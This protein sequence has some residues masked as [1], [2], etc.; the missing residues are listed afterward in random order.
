[1]RSA[2]SRTF[3]K[4]LLLAMVAL[5]SALAFGQ[6]SKRSDQAIAPAKYQ[7]RLKDDAFIKEGAAIFVPSC[8]ST[9][10]HGSAGMG[11]SAPRLRGR[12]LE[13]AYIFK[14]VSGGVP[15]TPMVSFKS[16]LTEEQRWKVVAF[17]MSPVGP[18]TGAGTSV[19]KVGSGAG[20]SPAARDANGE[21]AS[22][23][24]ST[25]A[26]AGT[27]RDLFYDLAN[28]HSC[29]G[30]H[31][32][33]GVGSK[34]G[35]DLAS[36]ASHSS[37]DLIAAIL[38][39]HTVSDPKYSTIT[40]TL[41]DGDKI[42]GIKKTETADAMRVY[43]VTVSPPVLRTVR[44]SEIIRTETSQQSVMPSNYGSIYTEKQL[45][46]IVAFIKSAASRTER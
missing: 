24:G 37:A 29:H 31:A 3:S 44:R 25:S 5:S 32:V 36:M 7:D 46:D 12:D 8:S 41:S 38:K 2:R 30:C 9:Y 19:S 42:V 39:P 35:P 20:S 1:M 14:T 21:S 16:E 10:C 11:G 13:A 27:G 18:T 33:S 17:I 28:Q 15:G 43:D 23:S 26:D 22:A 34:V 6:R 4:L 45:A 40:L